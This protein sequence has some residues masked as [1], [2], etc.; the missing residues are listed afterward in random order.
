MADSTNPLDQL[1]S[2]QSSKEIR[3]N[4]LFDAASPATLYGRRA[5]TTTGL[6]W[7]YYGGRYASF[8]V[9]NGTVTLTASTTNYVVA[10]KASGAVS[11][12]TAST[13]WDD[14]NNYERCYKI[15]TGTASVT[16]YED[17]RQAMGGGGSGGGGLTGFASSLNVLAPNAT[18]SVAQLLATGAQTNIDVAYQAKG[19]GA[20]LAQLPDNTTTGGNKRGANSVDWQNS[21]SAATQVASSTGCVIAGGQNNTA[22]QPNATV[23]GG[24]GNTASNT[25]ATVPGG[26]A[27]TA[28]GNYS[29]AMG[30]SCTASGQN[31]FAIGS[32]CA[33]SGDYSQARG[34]R[35][36]TRSIT[37]ADALASGSIFSTGDAQCIRLVL[38]QT[39]SDATA[40]PMTSDSSGASSTTNHLVLP[41]TSALC[42]TGQ[43]VARQNA[44]G[45]CKTWTFTAA[46]KRGAA[47]A[48]TAMVAACTPVVVAN[49]AGAAAWS[50]VVDANTT[51]GSLRLTVTGEAAKTIQWVALL[52]SAEVVG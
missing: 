25:G 46:I 41:N 7:G 5:A 50:L 32:S 36:S 35:A 51:Q 16:S 30:N 20:V 49:D 28:S 24:V 10:A 11:V 23:S 2:S 40:K 13:N 18:V 43:V 33:A 45:D 22:S 42:V 3:I 39:T 37:G 12:S 34:S 1:A 21:R 48:N 31:S 15:V 29:F 9:A 8:T 6:S 17:H 44:T 47:A 4:E 27:N 38:R 19:T 52:D 14:A 26:S